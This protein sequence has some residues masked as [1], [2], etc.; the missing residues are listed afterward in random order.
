MTDREVERS[1]T[2]TSCAPEGS[3][4]PSWNPLTEELDSARKRLVQDGRWMAF[5]KLRDSLLRELKME[6]L[7]AARTALKDF[8]PIEALTTEEQQERAEQMRL[9]FMTQAAVAAEKKAA[10]GG[11]RRAKEKAGPDAGLMAQAEE[12]RREIDEQLRQL[13]AMTAGMEP[14]FDRDWAWAYDNMAMPDAMPLMAPSTSAWGLLEWARESKDKFVQQYVAYQE[15]RRK[16]GD[17]STM[18]MEADRKTRFSVIDRLLA[19]LET[20]IEKSARQAVEISAEVVAGVLREAGWS[21][22]RMESAV[23]TAGQ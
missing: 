12:K 7:Q 10:G 14:D 9:A 19:F 2:D 16:D 20:D 6:P 5:L 11:G 13:A 3:T 21:V 15:K 8:P 22:A 18:E 4:C 17:A 23:D 1:T